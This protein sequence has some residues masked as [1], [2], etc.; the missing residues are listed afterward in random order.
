MDAWWWVCFF[1]G[2]RWNLSEMVSKE[3]VDNVWEDADL[4]MGVGKEFLRE[5][6]EDTSDV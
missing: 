4:G 3:S 6:V 5:D 1:T 2:L